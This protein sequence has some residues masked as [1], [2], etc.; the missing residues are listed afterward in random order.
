MYLI[1][2]FLNMF[3]NNSYKLII[4]KI[5][6]IIFLIRIRIILKKKKNEFIIK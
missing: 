5:F 3:S 1:F 6:D 2:L 4:F